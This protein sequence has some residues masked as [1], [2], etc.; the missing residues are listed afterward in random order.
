MFLF[1]NSLVLFG[2]IVSGNV[3]TVAST[4]FPRVSKKPI[5]ILISLTPKLP[6]FVT[7]T[8]SEVIR[9]E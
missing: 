7:L 2:G 1:I 4:G 3:T 5:L 9:K 8:E 6:L